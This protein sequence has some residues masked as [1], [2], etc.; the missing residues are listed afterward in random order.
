MN[1]DWTKVP[2]HTVDIGTLID[3]YDLTI[4]FKNLNITK[5]VYRIK[6][7]GMVIKIGMSADNSRTLGE[8]AYRQIG[9]SESWGNRRL[10]GSSGADWRIIEEEFRKQ[11]GINID[12]KDLSITIYDFTSYPFI[13]TDPWNEVYHA[14]Q[15]RIE[16]YKEIV[17]EKPI[18][19]VHDDENFRRRGH[20]PKKN[21]DGLFE[22]AY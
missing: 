6:F 20:I 17:G 15:E 10:N 9:H 16:T 22:L 8:R 3:P 18:G 5:Y 11:Y 21:F 14:E 2:K 1:I 12:R 13:T 7:K 19:N 4:T